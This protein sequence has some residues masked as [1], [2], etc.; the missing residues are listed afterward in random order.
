MLPQDSTNFKGDYG[1]GNYDSRHTFVGE[2]S[3]Q[4]PGSAHWRAAATGWQANGNFSFHTG[5]KKAAVNAN[6]LNPDAFADP[7]A[8]AWG[9]TRRNA[10]TAPGIG[11]GEPFNTQFALKIT[12]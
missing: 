11:A 10:Y 8:G 9:T 2:V 5:F 12:F 7:A 1:Q 6:W 4:V 3:F